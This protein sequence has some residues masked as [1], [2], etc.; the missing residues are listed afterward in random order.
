M[1]PV[2]CDILELDN[3][4]MEVPSLAP[5]AGLIEKTLIVESTELSGDGLVEAPMLFLRSAGTA[6]CIVVNGSLCRPGYA[7]MR[8]GGFG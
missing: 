1:V 6:L 8:N 4:G 3:E 5:D 2:P 7:G